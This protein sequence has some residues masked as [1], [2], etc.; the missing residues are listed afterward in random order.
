[1]KFGIAV[2]IFTQALLLG[3]ELSSRDSTGLISNEIRLYSD[4]TIDSSQVSINTIRILG[5]NLIVYGTVEGQITVVGGDIHIFP[6]AIVNGTII[7][8]G[9]EVHRDPS[10]QITGNIIEAGMDQGLIYRETSSDSTRSIKDDQEKSDFF[11]RKDLWYHTEPGII[12]YNRNEGLRFTP[13]YWNWDRDNQ[14]NIRLSFSFGYRFGSKEFI[15]RTTMEAVMFKKQHVTLF[16]SGFKIS[17]TDD[18]WRLPESENTW[19]GLLGR[20]DFYDRWDEIG[21]EA[22]FSLNF[23]RLKLKTK[24]IKA[25]RSPIQV[26]NKMWSLTT[27]DRPLRSNLITENR[28]MESIISTAAFRTT[29]Y[30]PVSTGFAVLTEIEWFLK[31]SGLSGSN[32]RLFSM[33][34]GGWEISE[35]IIFRVRSIL[36]MGSETVPA[37]RMFGVGGLG[38]VSGHRYKIQSG[39]TME[40]VNLELVFT[41]EFTQKGF[42]FKMFYDGGRAYSPSTQPAKLLQGA[43]F[44]FGRSKKDGLGIGFNV[45]RAL[46]GKNP[47]ESTVRLNYNF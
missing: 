45:G 8:I 46:G 20:Q 15:G 36:G 34:L 19:A 7:L 25:D 18:E 16:T 4:V 32:F 39:S 30:R 3:R 17:Q 13:L 40:Q 38:S 42:L 11:H 47:V 28:D 37:Y 35:G 26:T 2:L 5:G 10:A 1:M 43:G 23:D 9:G 44:G 29:G 22:G 33:I 27:S 41:E 12:A 14:S 21:L 24:Y 6:S 31:S